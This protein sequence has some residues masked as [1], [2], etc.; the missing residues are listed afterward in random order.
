MLCRNP[1]I[2]STSYNSTLDWPADERPAAEGFWARGAE[3]PEA[4]RFG[5]KGLEAAEPA[6]EDRGVGGIEEF[7][8]EGLGAEDTTAESFLTEDPAAGFLVGSWSRM[9][10]ILL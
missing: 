1:T 6:V 5:H 2:R 4:G 10:L 7:L 8:T 3:G 9:C